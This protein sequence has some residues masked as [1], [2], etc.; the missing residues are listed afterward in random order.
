MASSRHLLLLLI[1]IAALAACSARLS[2]E[3]PATEGPLV[4]APTSSPLPAATT[5]ATV[6]PPYTILSGE[7]SQEPGTILFGDVAGNSIA[8]FAG[9]PLSFTIDRTWGFGAYFG[10]AVEGQQVDVALARQEGAAWVPMWTK[11]IPVVSGRAGVLGTLPTFTQP[12][13]YRLDVMVDGDT[14]ATSLM[15][16]VPPCEGV[17]TGG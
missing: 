8:P 3:P 16:M 12:G 11:S 6:A 5:S 13:T 17:C 1:S 15:S 14:L 2:T 10:R 9:Y 7:P 4:I